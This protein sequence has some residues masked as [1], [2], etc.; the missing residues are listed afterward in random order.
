MNS[1]IGN[2][3]TASVRC[4]KAYSIIVLRDKGS[5]AYESVPE[6]MVKVSLLLGEKRSIESRS[7]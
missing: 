5:A 6:G 7:A 4:G 1:A 2:V 3:I